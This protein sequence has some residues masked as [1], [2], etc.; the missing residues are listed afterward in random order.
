M[1][2][3]VPLEERAVGRVKI[4]ER[5]SASS[6]EIALREGR[7][8]AVRDR[9][10]EGVVERRLAQPIAIMLL[11]AWM[12]LDLNPRLKSRYQHPVATDLD[13]SGSFGVE[14]REQVRYSHFA[15]QES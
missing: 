11:E 6:H 7:G 14:S 8:D 13:R 9:E 1:H 10:G 3:I 15:R 2:V 4:K 12:M 5:R